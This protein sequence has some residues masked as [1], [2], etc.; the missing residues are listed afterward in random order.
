M[1]HSLALVYR[2]IRQT[3]NREDRCSRDFCHSCEDE[4]E[5]YLGKARQGVARFVLQLATDLLLYANSSARS[6]APLF[7]RSLAALRS[8]EDCPWLKA[9]RGTLQTP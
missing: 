7:F 5:L 3:S 6:L 2:F 8:R 1:N 9:H 4:R